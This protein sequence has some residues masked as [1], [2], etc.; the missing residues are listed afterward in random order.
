MN[1][2]SPYL[3]ASY[4]FIIKVLDEKNVIQARPTIIYLCRI[5]KRSAETSQGHGLKRNKGLGVDNVAIWNS[6][7]NSIMY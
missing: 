7:Y 6:K 5:V 4:A 3:P 2:N 1:P